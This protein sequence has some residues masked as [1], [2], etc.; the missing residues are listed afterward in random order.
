MH[1]TDEAARQAQADA[2]AAYATYSRYIATTNLTGLD[3]GGLVL[4]PGVYNFSSSAHLTGN[5]TLDYGADPAG[6]FLFLIGSTLTTASDSSVTV[7]NG[8]ASSGLF[9]NVGSSATL[10]TG[11]SFMGNILA[12]QSIT[13]NTG[14]QIKCGRAI[15]L[16]AAVTL[17]TN[18]LSNNCYGDG[19]LASGATDFGSNAFSGNV[20]QVSGAVPEPSIWAMM[21]F[22]FSLIG[23][24][25]RRRKS[26]GL[27]QQGT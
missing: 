3:L 16:N 15:A 22:G 1:P 5:L 21:I 13:M 11:T 20:G 2:I 23:A 27:T 14:A 26:H 7:L 17:D 8:G 4:S 25:L 9:F 6:S 19:A 18:K 24:M 12:M 10:G